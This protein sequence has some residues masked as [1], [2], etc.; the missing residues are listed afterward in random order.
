MADV[1][2]CLGIVHQ[3]QTSVADLSKAESSLDMMT[4][5]IHFR[6]EM[7]VAADIIQKHTN[8]NNEL[9]KQSADIYYFV[10][11]G[12]AD[13]ENNFINFMENYFNDPNNAIAKPG[14]HAA[15]FGEIGARMTEF[16]KM[17]PDNT[18]L[19]AYSIMDM[20]RTEDGKV[21]RLTISEEE[22]EM[23]VYKLDNAFGEVVKNGIR[24]GQKPVE[25]SASFLYELLA[26]SKWKSSD[27][28]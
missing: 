17:L 6:N 28:K 15:K 24:A 22:R 9:I 5:M 18:M 25:A 20:K 10:Y 8:S 19:A 3:A 13:S 1:I 4:Q 21:N 11:S 27:A 7:N 26:K 14:T 12:V 23:L 16:W 2:Q